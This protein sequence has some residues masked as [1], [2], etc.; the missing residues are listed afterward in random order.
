MA[1]VIRDLSRRR[2]RICNCGRI[3]MMCFGEQDLLAVEIG[4]NQEKVGH[5][6]GERAGQRAAGKAQIGDENNTG[7]DA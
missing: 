7:D 5:N 2:G 1:R 4:W 3:E 6:P